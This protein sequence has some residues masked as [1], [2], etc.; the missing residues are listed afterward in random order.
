MLW[1]FLS[2]LGET[3]LLIW[4]KYFRKVNDMNRKKKKRRKSDSNKLRTV[5]DWHSGK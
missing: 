4:L 1:P 3:F 2:F 5:Q